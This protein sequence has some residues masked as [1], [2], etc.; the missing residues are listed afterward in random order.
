MAEKLKS[1]S[2]QIPWYLAVKAAAFGFAWYAMPR[3]WFLVVALGLY[4]IPLFHT[5]R[6]AVPMATLLIVSDLIPHGPYAGLVALALAGAFFLLDGVKN[7]V[8]IDRH[9]AYRALALV[10][11]FAA[12]ALFFSRAI[13]SSDGLCSPP[14]MVVLE[15]LIVAGVAFF[16]IRDILRSASHHAQESAT[17]AAEHLANSHLVAGLSTI[18]LWE[19][20]WVLLFLPLNFFS[21]TAL[22]F[23]AAVMVLELCELRISHRLDRRAI[24]LHTSI[25]ITFLV[26][27]LAANEWTV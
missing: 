19:L 8:F 15:S 5:L 13:C 1:I 9:A 14:G 4:C 27:L 23:L 25:L 22:A 16:V 6:L 3:G 24:L 12:L 7:L 18:L 17:A 2:A 10:L 26:V 11:L 20:W 21:Q